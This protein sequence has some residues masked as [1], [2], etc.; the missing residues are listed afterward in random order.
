MQEP[1]SEVVAL[2]LA[3]EATI[4]TVNLSE[5]VSKLA[6]VGMAEPAIREAI[7]S[8]GL[9]VE[10]FDAQL[11][12][13]VGM[14]RPVTKQAGLSLGDRACLALGRRLGLEVLTADRAWADLRVGVAIRAI[15]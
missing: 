6:E 7:D 12:Y 8:L 2:A 14:L 1:G 4:G 10:P 3:A 11:A 13:A 5:V 9:D 15:R